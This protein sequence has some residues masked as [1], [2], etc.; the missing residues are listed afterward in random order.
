MT[1]LL[2]GYKKKPEIR[3]LL[4]KVNMTARM[5]LKVRFFIPVNPVS[6]IMILTALKR[7]SVNSTERKFL[8]IWV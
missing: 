4:S 7:T 8:R 2:M 1:M 6:V 3:I 5:A